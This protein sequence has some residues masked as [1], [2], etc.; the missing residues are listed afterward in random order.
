MVSHIATRDLAITGS[1]V[2][3]RLNVDRSAVSRAVQRVGKDPELISAART[4]L[5]LLE[6]ELSQH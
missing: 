5:G 6:S 1:D 3:R 2:A 4:I